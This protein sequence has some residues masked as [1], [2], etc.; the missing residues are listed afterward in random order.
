MRF[1]MKKIQP[2]AQRKVANSAVLFQNKPFRKSPGEP[3]MAGPVKFE[4]KKGI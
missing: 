2:F 4:P 1:Q 3:N